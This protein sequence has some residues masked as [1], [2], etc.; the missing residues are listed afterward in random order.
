MRTGRSGLEC[1]SCPRCSPTFDGDDAVEWET[2]IKTDAPERLD[3]LV[4][5][6]LAEIE[7]FGIADNVHVTSFYW[8]ALERVRALNPTIKIAFIGKYDSEDDLNTA[9]ELWRVP[10]RYP[11]RDQFSGHR[12]GRARSGVDRGR[13]AVKRCRCLG[14]PDRLGRHAPLHR[15]TESGDGVFGRSK[16]LRVKSGEYDTAVIVEDANAVR[17]TV[18]TW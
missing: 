9:L 2:E 14:H 11:N 15:L 12:A 16:S 1:L 18:A 8:T 7:R 17:D 3:A 10:S 5:L 6:L 4:P 13:L